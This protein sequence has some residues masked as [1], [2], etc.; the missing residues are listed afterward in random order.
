MLYA[1]ARDSAKYLGP[2]PSALFEVE[3]KETASPSKDPTDSPS[4]APMTYIP[5][6]A[7]ICGKIEEFIPFVV[8]SL[9]LFILF[10]YKTHVRV[11]CSRDT[12]SP[13]TDPSV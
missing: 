3:R 2:V 7:H 9:G 1:Q 5:T 6:P 4:L 13:S 8:S 10:T 12:V 11:C